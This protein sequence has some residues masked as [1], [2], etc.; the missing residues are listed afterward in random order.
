V[1]LRANG[2]DVRSR[3]VV[4]ATG[5]ATPFFAPLAASFRMWHTYVAA[6]EPIPAAVRRALGLGPVMLWDAGRP[7]HYGRW[8]G[9]RLVLGGGDRPPV[10]GRRRAQAL[11]AGVAGVWRFFRD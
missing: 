3:V 9:S 4:V 11:R 1:R 7:Y 2:H 10:P 5:Y 6:T 8:M